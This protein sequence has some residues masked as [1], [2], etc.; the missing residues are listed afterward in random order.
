M[1]A[2]LGKLAMGNPLRVPFA[3]GAAFVWWG[4]LIPKYA[5]DTVDAETDKKVDENA[6]RTG[7]QTATN[8]RTCR[9]RRSTLFKIFLRDSWEL[10][11]R[12]KS[13]EFLK[14]GKNHNMVRSLTKVV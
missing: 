14:T 7:E 9:N 2:G 1:L 3:A 8:Q 13:R 12:L 5:P 4:A 11:Q 6:K 10:M